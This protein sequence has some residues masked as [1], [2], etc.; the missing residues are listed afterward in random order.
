MVA[1]VEGDGDDEAITASKSVAA[2]SLHVG[3]MTQKEEGTSDGEPTAASDDEASTASR[4]TRVG[5]VEE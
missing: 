5:A 1:P 3:E 4:S 2:S